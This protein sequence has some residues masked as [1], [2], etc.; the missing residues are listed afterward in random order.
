MSRLR[1]RGLRRCVR[2]SLPLDGV[3]QVGTGYAVPAGTAVATYEDMTVH[4]ALTLPYP[5]WQALSSA[6]RAAAVERQARAYAQART[7]CFATRWAAQSAVRDYGV[8]EDRARVI[9]IGRNHSPRPLPRDWDSPRFLFVG[10]DWQ[11]KNGDSVVRTFARVRERIPSARLDVSGGHPRLDVEGVTGH[12]WLSL[13]DPN[14]RS[15]LDRLFEAAT[16]FVMPSW[17]EPAG[18]VYLEAGAAGVA[19][20]GSTVGG[21]A[22]LI[23]EGGTAVNPGDDEGL[24]EAMLHFSEGDVAREAGQRA[25]ARADDFTWSSVAGRILDALALAQHPVL[26][27]EE[28]RGA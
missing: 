13:N 7:C 21:G 2:E 19:S 22:E 20:I 16:C 1:S 9:G 6:E 26:A 4:Q 11:R 12:G 17:V 15:K 25:L 28:S 8:P 5:E 23:G 10:G 3:V 24:L 18:I 14:E 27:V